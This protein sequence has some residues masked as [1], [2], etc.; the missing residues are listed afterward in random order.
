M[1]ARTV[2]LVEIMAGTIVTTGIATINNDGATLIPQVTIS[3]VETTS[4]RYGSSKNNYRGNQNFR[5]N[6]KNNYQ[7]RGN[8]NNNGYNRNR[9]GNDNGTTAVNR[10]E[11]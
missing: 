2:I 11:M 4:N 8:R 6:G 3:N 10:E 1:H 7:T 5:G 9:G